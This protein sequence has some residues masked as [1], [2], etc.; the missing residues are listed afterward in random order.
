M[1][2]LIL[3]KDKFPESLGGGLENDLILEAPIIG[4]DKKRWLVAFA[5]KRCLKKEESI[6]FRLK[7]EELTGLKWD[8]D[9]VSSFVFH[10]VPNSKRRKIMSKSKKK[11]KVPKGGQ[12]PLMDVGPE[13]NQEI[14]DAVRVYKGY[15]ADRLAAGKK[16]FKAKEAVKALVLKSNLKP[17]KDGVIKF[18]CGNSEVAVTPR[19]IL[20]TIKEIK[21]KK[22]KKG[23]KGKVESEEQQHEDKK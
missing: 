12:I 21:G 15:Q 5:N 7:L 16:E 4:L 6:A 3:S 2:T 14:V 22:T 9:S 13:N 1:R 20:I 10:Y 19:D 23:M 17:F 11:A 8:R 18:T